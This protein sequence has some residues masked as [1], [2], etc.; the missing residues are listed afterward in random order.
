MSE[1]IVGLSGHIDHGKTSIIKSL[2]DQ[3]SGT[4]KEDLNR[5]MTVDLG[6]AFLN[7]K[8]TLIDVPGHKDYLK[9]MLSGVQSIDVGLLVIAA[10]DGIMPQTI[11]HFNILKLLNISELIILINKVDLVDEEMIELVKSEI[12]DLINGSIFENAKILNI[13]TLKNL[14]ISE[15]KKTLENISKIDKKS[16]GAFRMPIDRIFSIKGFGT[17]VTG[18]VISGSINI[19]DEIKIEPISKAA[20]IRGINSHNNS[21]KSISKGQRAAIN[22]Q[23]IDKSDLKRGYQIVDKMLY[24]GIKSIIAEI[25]ILNEIDRPIKRNQRIRIHLGTAEVIG[26]IFLFDRKNLKGNEKAHVL[27]NFEKPIVGTFNDRFIIRHYSPVFTLG[28][29]TIILHSKIKNHFFNQEM[30]LSKISNI[31]DEINDLNNKKVIEYIISKFELN[32]TSFNNL[33]TQLG[34]SKLQLNNI[35]KI[36]DNILQIKYLN[37]YWLTTKKQISFL[38]GKVND[39]IKTFF[40]QNVYSSSIN[41]EIIIN[42]TNINGN[43][44]DYLLTLLQNDN[45]IEKKHDGWSL[46][47]Y[48]VKLSDDDMNNKKRL[49]NILKD[50]GINTSSINELITKCNIKDEKTLMKIIKICE[51]DNLIIRL[52]QSILLLNTNLVFIKEQL[53]D[54]FKKNNSISVPQFKE[55]LK[56]SRKYAIPILEHLDKIKF[57][58]RNGNVRELIK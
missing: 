1:I 29:G 52:D 25:E 19:G 57:T 9:N 51:N 27:I 28:A 31:I 46:F 39:C 10:D 11:D 2:T 26:Q 3:F 45:V 8:I 13:S 18:T 54:F 41:K 24:E 44:I 30:K 38:K 50:E 48:K 49:L 4:L 40:K 12:I 5:G 20:K 16:D 23:N 37:K 42:D 21:S 6:I 58:Q 36:N 56:I 47:K 43:F 34:Y 35:L 14:G 22:L 33:C 15:L 17:V 7:E 55:L 32:P 53:A